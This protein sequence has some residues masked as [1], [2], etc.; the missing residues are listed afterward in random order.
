MHGMKQQQQRTTTTRQQQHQQQRQQ[1][2]SHQT[3]VAQGTT[4]AIDLIS[5]NL[6]ADEQS[7]CTLT[8]TDVRASANKQQR[9]YAHKNV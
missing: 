4:I 7:I 5:C 8:I 2:Q 3:H 1:Q 9:A 6:A